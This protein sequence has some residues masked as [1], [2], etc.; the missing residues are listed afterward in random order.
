LSDL[1]GLRRRVADLAASR[2]RLAERIAREGD[3]PELRRQL[4]QAAEAE[5]RMAETS[6]WAQLRVDA[7]RSTKEVLKARLAAARAQGAVYG[8]LAGLGLGDDEPGESADAEASL[9]DIEQ[10]IQ[11]EISRATSAAAGLAETDPEPGLA[12]LRTDAPGDAE[13]HVLF[14]VE[15]P[16]T[17]L[18]IAVVEGQ[19]AWREHR[20]E[21]IGLS[22]EVLR[23]VQ[24]GASPESATRHYDGPRAFLAGF[25]PA[26][27]GQIEA[28]AA[29]L[30]A[31]DRGQG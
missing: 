22:A 13:I 2:Q 20:D 10:Q 6:Q 15:P 27:A 9:R 24:A 14:A 16:G 26:D 8:A 25:F 21:A 19:Q 29:H 12:E 1:Q 28:A 17:V 7:F 23:N 30:A 11:R 5:Q 18:L 31:Q 4:D 3:R